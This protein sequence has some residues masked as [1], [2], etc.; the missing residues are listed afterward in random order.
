MNHSDRRGLPY[1]TAG[2][3]PG[4]TGTSRLPSPASLLSPA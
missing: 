4:V 1:A 2:P 3:L